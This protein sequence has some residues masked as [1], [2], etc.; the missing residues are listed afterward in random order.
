MK[1]TDRLAVIEELLDINSPRTSADIISIS[2]ANLLRA[3]GHYERTQLNFPPRKAA[4]NAL[5]EEIEHT[6]Q[7]YLSVQQAYTS[8]MDDLMKVETN[9]NK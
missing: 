6:E 4:L 8:L 3:C 7:R 9:E 2:I 5:L 1:A